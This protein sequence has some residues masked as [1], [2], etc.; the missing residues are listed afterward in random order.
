M[1]VWELAAIY[2]VKITKSVSMP[3][4]PLHPTVAKWLNG[5]IRSSRRWQR[6]G[7]GDGPEIA[8]RS[9]LTCP[10]QLSGL[11]LAAWRFL[12]FGLGSARFFAFAAQDCMPDSVGR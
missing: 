8:C 12:S 6:F 9:A 3:K 11:G 2:L 5:R 10:F 1:G 4:D 7:R